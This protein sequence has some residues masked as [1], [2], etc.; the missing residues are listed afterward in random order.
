[1]PVAQLLAAIQTN[2]PQQTQIGNPVGAEYWAIGLLAAVLAL[3]ILIF[4]RTSM[5]R[6]SK[7]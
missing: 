7:R 3:V 5:R 4:I 1:M 2:G 6:L